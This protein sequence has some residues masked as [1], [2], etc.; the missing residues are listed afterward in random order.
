MKKIY[1]PVI[2]LILFMLMSGFLISC[3]KNSFLQANNTTNLT[4]S[5]IF[6]DSAY[7]V[8]FLANIY[9]NIDFSASPSRFG[10][11]TLSNTIIPCGGLDAASDESEVSHTYST[12]ALEF[13]LGSIDQNNVTDD[14]FKTCY[15]QIRAVNQL[16]Q[17][18]PKAPLQAA[19]KTEMLAEARFLRAYYYFI[20][21]EHY[22]GVPLVGYNIYDYTQPIPET[23]ATFDQTVTYIIS[24]LDSAQKVLPM[25]QTG[26][27][28]GRASGSICM[29]L[30][31]RLLL[32]AA[33]PM[34]NEPNGMAN[35]G[36]L[37]IASSAQKPL[38]GYTDYQLSRWGLAKNAAYAVISLG[39]YR[40]ATDSNYLA[41]YGEEGAFQYMFTQRQNPEY[42]F[43]YNQPQSGGLAANYLEGLFNPPSRTGANGAFPYQSMVDA[44]PMQNGKDI[45]DPTSG[46][47]PANP[48]ANRDP[49]LRYSIVYNGS[50]LPIRENNGSIPGYA[51]IITGIPFVD[52][53]EQQ[54]GQDAVHQ[55]TITGYYNNKM[56]DPASVANAGLA[57]PTNRCLPVIRFAEML[58]DYAEASNELNG[59]TDSVYLSLELIRKRAG[60]SPGTTLDVAGRPSYGLAAGMSQAQMRTAI[61]NERRI[62]LAYEGHRF[63]DVRRWLIA[64]QTE[65]RQEYGMQ[66]DMNS[67]SGSNVVTLAY[68]TFAVRKHNFSTRMY[69]WPFPQSEIGKGRGLIQNPGY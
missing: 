60:I 38:V 3:K 8:G 45:T 14:A 33:S 59:P 50:L 2:V 40:L 18:L 39:Q 11:K 17:S 32:Y 61:Q 37:D 64:D 62:E 69:L 16:F 25:V 54:G 5:V 36:P 29:A 55:G 46:Y 68:K 10:Y 52:G 57:S 56:V 65:S 35:K 4:Q 15:G 30:K 63:F 31:A 53:V 48:Y 47:N 58:L 44:F 12:T 66:V 19:L 34:F 20:L 9:S 1:V 24:Q 28:L 42:I 23:R 51:P 27:N 6:S 43:Q 49:R 7:T 67:N 41:G 22:G 21:L 26:A 13:A